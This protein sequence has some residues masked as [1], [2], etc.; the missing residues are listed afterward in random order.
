MASGCGYFQTR[1]LFDTGL[2][3][4]PF[5]RFWCAVGVALLLVLPFVA[6]AFWL[7][8]ANLAIIAVIGALALNL[9]TGY[10]GQLSLGHGGF[11]AAGAFTSAVLVRELGAPWWLTWP[12]A[13]LVGALVGVLVGVPALRLRGIYLAVSTLAAHFV[14]LALASEY[15]SHVGRGAALLLPTPNLFGWQLR[16]DRV[17]Y[18]VL[19][20]IAVLV[21]V[22]CVN[23][24]R[25]HVGR[26]WLTIRERDLAAAAL[27]IDVRRY[28]IM[29]F[30]ISTALTS[31]AGALWGY[32]TTFVSV[33]AFGFLITVE[34][35]AM[36]I[37]GGMGSVLGS[38]YGA[39]FITVLPAAVERTLQ[40]LPFA[41]ALERHVFAVQGAV[42]AL[43]M[44]GFL[45]WEPR[46][47]VALWRRLRTYFELWPFRRRPADY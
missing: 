41:R 22:I 25:S 13:L 30:V 21:T 33:E 6:P 27:G 5:R 17:W 18:F 26:A 1:Y 20:V 23:L 45:F 19:L 15:Q 28:K 47:L 43:L 36:I 4:T 46:G 11:L 2:V 37:V 44:I 39:L 31:F 29:A 42:F 40:A 38:I 16:G 3:E 34:Y 35:L 12:A 7:G 8:I 32:Y 9:L 10:A 14:I 24:M